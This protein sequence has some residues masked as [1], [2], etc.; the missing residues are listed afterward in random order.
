M[1]EVVVRQLLDEERLATLE[2]IETLTSTLEGVIESSA[3]ANA[4]DEHDPEGS[5]I[6]FERAQVIS[7]LGESQSQLAEIDQALVRIGA[8]DYGLCVRCG[9]A[10]GAE[11]LMA[12][13]AATLC[14]ECAGMPV[15]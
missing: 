2:R 10:I 7:L 15:T 9:N 14:I 11:R 12:R 13:P 4:D 1:D 8:G 6:A 5:T 3:G